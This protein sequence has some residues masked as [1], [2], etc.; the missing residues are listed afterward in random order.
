MCM[1]LPL[2]TESIGFMGAI[3]TGLARAA[4]EEALAY[5]RER[6]QGGKPLCEHQ[7]VKQKLYRMFERVESSRY[8]TRKVMEHVWD[9]VYTERTFDA[10]SR[11]ALSAQICGTSTAFEVA[12]EAVQLHGAYGL[13]RDALVEKLFRDARASLIMDGANDVLSLSAAYNIV[14]EY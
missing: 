8:Y 3:F 9:R 2:I 11:H 14:D 10:S 13:T 5:T 12:H 6:V 1:T 7:S 4:F